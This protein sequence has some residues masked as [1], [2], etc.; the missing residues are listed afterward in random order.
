MS[1]GRGLFIK[2]ADLSPCASHVTYV[3]IIHKDTVL[4]WPPILLIAQQ[5]QDVL[6]SEESHL[7]GLIIQILCLE[8]YR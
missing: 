5:F 7:K 4:H 3:H 8:K 1:T 2:M 6:M